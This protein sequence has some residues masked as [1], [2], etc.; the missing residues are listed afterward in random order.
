VSSSRE[1]GVMEGDE[2]GR[3]NEVERGRKDDLYFHLKQTRNKVMLI[4]K[5]AYQSRMQLIEVAIASLLPTST[6]TSRPPPTHH[7]RQ[8]AGGRC[9]SGSTGRD[10]T[11]LFLPP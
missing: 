11:S 2:A 5:V 10:L 6:T 7:Y 3:S 8:P 4:Q 1:K 9:G